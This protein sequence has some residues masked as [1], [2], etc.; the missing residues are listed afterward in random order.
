MKLRG[1]KVILFLLYVCIAAPLIRPQVTKDDIKELLIAQGMENVGHKASEL[2]NEY[3][4]S[5]RVTNYDWGKAAGE[6]AL[7]GICMGLN[8]SRTANYSNVSWMPAAVRN[9]YNNSFSSDLLFS[10]AFTWQKVW[11]EFDYASDRMAYNDLKYLFKNNSYKAAALQF[12]I[13]NIAA[14]IV[15]NEMKNGRMF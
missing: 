7:S 4:A 5:H 9:W 12:I 14:L 1:T 15:R 6:S 10:K 2:F 3:Y 11:R 8:Q 13:K